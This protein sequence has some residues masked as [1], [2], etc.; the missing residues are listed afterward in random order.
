VGKRGGRLLLQSRVQTLRTRR[1]MLRNLRTPSP[2]E[3]MTYPFV[4]MWELTYSFVLPPEEFLGDGI[5]TPMSFFCLVWTIISNKNLHWSALL[6]SNLATSQEHWRAIQSVK[7]PVGKTPGAWDQLVLY[8]YM[9]SCTCTHVKS[10]HTR[11]GK[12]KPEGG[13]LWTRFC[14]PFCLFVSALFQSSIIGVTV[15]V[16]A[17]IWMSRNQSHGTHE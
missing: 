2:L 13:H 11:A 9:I 4:N 14:S 7:R 10:S 12:R 5:S 16:M 15:R 3:D 6:A 1:G 17:H 8:I